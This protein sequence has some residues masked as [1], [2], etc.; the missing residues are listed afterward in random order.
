MSALCR[1][2]SADIPVEISPGTGPKVSILAVSRRC[3]RRSCSLRACHYRA[4]AT[5]PDVATRQQVCYTLPGVL[6]AVDPV[7]TSA[8][9]VKA[10]SP[11]RLSSIHTTGVLIA[12]SVPTKR[13]DLSWSLAAAYGMSAFH[14]WQAIGEEYVP[15]NSSH[16]RGT[17]AVAVCWH[18]LHAPV[19]IYMWSHPLAIPTV[20][21]NRL[22]NVT[23]GRTRSQIGHNLSCFELR[24]DRARLNQRY[25]GCSG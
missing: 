10:G 9:I 16:P 21:V 18:P 14:V 13:T 19:S 20:T 7:S 8:A 23:A 11:P 15:G 25:G 3:P 24:Y 1:P 4:A 22:A 17:V 2:Q 6:G 5:R 12:S